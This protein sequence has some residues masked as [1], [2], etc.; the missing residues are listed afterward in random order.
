MSEFSEDDLEEE[1]QPK[2]GK[3]VNHP[4]SDDE[5]AE[6]GDK[7]KS[8]LEVGRGLSDA[9]TRGGGTSARTMLPCVEPVYNTAPVNVD[10][11]FKKG[12]QVYNSESPCIYTKKQLFEYSPCMYWVDVMS[13]VCTEV[14]LEK[15]GNVTWFEA[16]GCN[17]GKAWGVPND[18]KITTRPKYSEMSA[19][20]DRFRNPFPLGCRPPNRVRHVKIPFILEVGKSAIQF[21]KDLAKSVP[22]IEVDCAIKELLQFLCKPQWAEDNGAHIIPINITFSESSHFPV[23]MDKVLLSRKVDEKSLLLKHW[24]SPHGPFARSDMFEMREV[25]HKVAGFESPKIPD[26]YSSD[27]TQEVKDA[28]YA[29]AKGCKLTK[30]QEAIIESQKRL[31]KSKKLTKLNMSQMKDFAEREIFKRSYVNGCNWSTIRAGKTFVPAETQLYHINECLNDPEFGRY[32][33]FPFDSVWSYVERKLQTLEDS[34]FFDIPL[35]LP[36]PA[37]GPLVLTALERTKPDTVAAKLIQWFV[38]EEFMEIQK[39]TRH[40]A[41]FDPTNIEG[42][43][44]IISDAEDYRKGTSKIT[45]PEWAHPDRMNFPRM[46]Q[47][48]PLSYKMF[49]DKRA[50]KH[51]FDAKRKK[52]DRREFAMNLNDLQL[53]LFPTAGFKAPAEIMD[54]Q[55]KN[56]LTNMPTVSYHLEVDIAYQLY[57]SG[58]D[59]DEELYTHL[60]TEQLSQKPALTPSSQFGLSASSVS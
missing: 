15:I 46:I 18:I 17:G 31:I 3:R 43:K 36:D 10:S 23:S 55:S 32:C 28:W 60:I 52:F 44:A 54:V 42:V 2:R 51:I 29:Y 59:V 58:A 37:Q 1:T 24:S 26:P 41:L 56:V 49:V 6:W 27:A 57:E 13:K 39:L 11:H 12:S 25:N 34:P 50:L 16:F 47:S 22:M 53:V 9:W 35:P 14:Y 20:A 7:E 45:P 21:A 8:V 30:A 33:D 48:V 40:N 5:D 4:Q 38:M 19:L